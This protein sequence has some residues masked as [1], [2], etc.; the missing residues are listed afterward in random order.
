MNADVLL[1]LGGIALVMLL[2]TG[3]L[4]RFKGWLQNFVTTNPAGIP[5]QQSVNPFSP[6]S[7]QGGDLAVQNPG[8]SGPA[9][10]VQ[11]GGTYNPQN[12]MFTTS[13]NVFFPEGGQVVQGFSSLLQGKSFQAPA[14]YDAS[15]GAPI[16]IQTTPG[17][18]GDT[19]A[20][21]Q[22]IIGSLTAADISGLQIKGSNPNR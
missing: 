5:F 3:Q 15:S 2:A 20:L 7:T 10:G 17:F 22:R 11:L 12:N 9:A 13:G 19:L 18:G 21:A 1:P 4:T 6:V 8:Q 16:P 14:G